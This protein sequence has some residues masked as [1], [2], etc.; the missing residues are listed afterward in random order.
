M[1]IQFLGLEQKNHLLQQCSQE[2]GF[3]DKTLRDFQLTNPVIAHTRQ[4]Q[5]DDG[6]LSN[7]SKL[8]ERQKQEKCFGGISS[9]AHGDAGRMMEAQ[10][11]EGT[12]GLCV[13]PAVDKEMGL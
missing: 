9:K 5:N 1:R 4:I 11:G 3:R 8:Q 13:S 6:F 10:G 2:T 12:G 7:I